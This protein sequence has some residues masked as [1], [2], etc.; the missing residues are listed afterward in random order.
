[1]KRAHRTAAAPSRRLFAGAYVPDNSADDEL[2]PAPKKSRLGKSIAST[3]ESFEDANQVMPGV[4]VFTDTNDR[5]PEL[6]D[7]DDNPFVL[8]KG[9]KKSPIK[10]S[11]TKSSPKRSY[12]MG[13]DIDE[14]VRN[15]KGMI[16]TL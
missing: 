14:A 7:N 16:Y 5:I 6:D 10:S 12:G 13:K 9:K 3:L 8:K 15:N 1:M 4:D 11:A 2:M